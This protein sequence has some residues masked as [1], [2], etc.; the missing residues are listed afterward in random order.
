MYVARDI[1]GNY[2]AARTV[3]LNVKKPTTSLTFDDM[4]GSKYYNAALTM[5]EE[6]IMSGTKVGSHTYFYPDGEVSRGD[7]VVMTLHALGVENVDA[8]ASTV[9]ADNAEIPEHVRGYVAAAY[10]LGYISGVQTERG[11]CFEASRSITRAEAAVIL[12][13]ALDLA[14]PTVLPT[15][16]DSADIPAWA[17]PSVYTLSS[18]GIM[19]ATDGNISATGTLCRKDAACILSE[20]ISYLD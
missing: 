12:G 3:S 4:Q 9:F 2:S 6:G 17:A 13:N 7:F 10:E 16:N 14:V 1:Y 19:S 5:A 8:Q 11:L 20:L 18:I 15:F